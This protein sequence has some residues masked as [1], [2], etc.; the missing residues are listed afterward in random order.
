MQAEKEVRDPP[1]IRLDPTKSQ[2]CLVRG[3]A[4][5]YPDHFPGV[6]YDSTVAV[7]QGAWPAT[8]VSTITL[9]NGTEV[10][11]P[12]G[13]YQY[14]PVESV[15]VEEDYHLE[16]WTECPA[17]TKDNAAWYNSSQFQAKA[18]EAAPFIESVS[19]IVGGRPATLQNWWNI[20]DYINVNYVSQSLNPVAPQNIAS[21]TVFGFLT[22]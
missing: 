12:L 16:S 14:I 3:L 2:I 17:Y 13:G 7:T 10:T 8:S 11:S 1:S 18:Q 22:D 5:S 4:L 6:I 21:E 15:E 20:F 19:S 9:A